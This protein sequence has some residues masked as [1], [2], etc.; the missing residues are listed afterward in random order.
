MF[1]HQLPTL[2]AIDT[3]RYDRGLAGFQWGMTLAGVG[4][5]VVA[6]GLLFQKQKE[7]APQSSVVAQ[8]VAAAVVAAVG[9]G[10]IGYAWIGF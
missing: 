9:L 8:R 1:Y 4:I 5:L 7:D 6:A 10:V 2:F 3:P